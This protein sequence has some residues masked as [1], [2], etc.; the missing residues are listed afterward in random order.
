MIENPKILFVLK[1]RKHNNIYSVSYGLLNSVKFI[2]KYLDSKKIEHKVVEV[3]DGNFIDKEIFIYKPT[4]VILEALWCP[5][6][7]IEELSKLYPNIKFNVRIHSKASFLAAEGIGFQWINEILDIAQNKDNVSLSINSADFYDD[8][9][10]IR[11]YVQDKIYYLPNLY[12]SKNDFSNKKSDKDVIKIGCFGALRI[13]KNHIVQAIAAI[14]LADKY[15]KKLEF[16]INVSPLENENNSILKNLRNLFSKGKHELVEHDW[17]PHDIFC[18]LIKE[19]DLGL[20]LSFT[21]SFNIVTADFVANGVPILTSSDI[22]IVPFF[23]KISNVN[24]TD[25]ISFRLHLLNLLTKFSFIK[26]I[27]LHSLYKHNK[28]SIIYWESFIHDRPL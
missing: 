25:K 27:A 9:K 3:I 28:E 8:L 24:N 12:I 5:P 4:H 7:K 13:L 10:E 1:E 20:Q 22:N 17:M 21:E 19:M 26:R 23:Y 16:H 6:Y 2:G 18:K 11:N 15:N 14:K